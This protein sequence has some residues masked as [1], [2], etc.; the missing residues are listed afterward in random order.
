MRRWRTSCIGCITRKKEAILSLISRKALF[1]A[2][3]VAAIALT[4]GAGSA[5]LAEAIVVKSAGPSARSYPP[6]RSIP[7]NSKV[8]L[9][10]GDTL[11]VL[12]GQG[13]RVFKGPG[14]FATTTTTRASSATGVIL[15]NTGTRQVRT[16][17]VRGTNTPA[18]PRPPNVWLIDATK[19]GSV[20]YAGPEP[21]S[22]WK[23]SSEQPTNIEITRI[24]DG[25]AVAV[26]LRPGQSV[27]SWP[28]AELPIADGAQYRISGDG[29][30]APVTL[31]FAA[32]G[33][34]PQG[35]EGTAAALIK[36]GCTAQL[37]LLIE[38]LAVPAEDGG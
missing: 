4:V 17:A 38:T 10:A 13:T 2:A 16:G 37:D 8:S 19:S 34:D 29:L 21:V 31:R 35:L 7:D 15:R 1:R 27:K 24:S 18:T 28:M 25:K 11:T 33:A 22:L 36:A 12:D 5:A 20:C 6:G 30:S 14:V 26:A 9:K 3:R 32:I 23:P